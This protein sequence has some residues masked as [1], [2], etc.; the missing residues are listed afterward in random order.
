MAT[1]PIR[2]LSLFS[3]VNGLGL[4]VKLALPDSEHVCY[5]EREIEACEVLAARMADGSIS[6]APIFTDITAFNGK[7]WRGAVDLIEGGFPCTDLSVAGRQAGIHGEKSGLWFEYLRII[8]EVQPR[9]VFI[10]NVPAVIAFPAG[11]IVLSG[12]AEAG[13][14]AEW[15][16]LQA[17]EVG[18]SHKR[19]RVFILAYRTSRRFGELRESSG[20]EGLANRGNEELEHSVNGGLQDRRTSGTGALRDCGD[21]DHGSAAAEPDR[22]LEYADSK[23]GDLQQ[24]IN[25]SQPDRA[26]LPLAHTP[27]DNGGRRERGTEAGAGPQGIGGGGPASGDGALAHTDGQ[28]LQIGDRERGRAEGECD[29]ESQCSLQ[30]LVDATGQGREEPRE[31]DG[32]T[33]GKEGQSGLFDGSE[34]SGS[35]LGNPDQPGLEGWS[36]SRQARG[37]RG[38]RASESAGTELADTGCER[39]Q[40]EREQGEL[41]GTGETTGTQGQW[42]RD[43][44]GHSST[45]IPLFAPG[46]S[47]SRWPDILRE[48]PWLAPAISED[49]TIA[50]FRGE[51]DGR[52]DEFDIKDRTDRLRA[53]GNMVCP[54]QAC[55]G[56]V[57]LANRFNYQWREKD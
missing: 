17:S 49:E 4:G 36:E 53:I 5:V 6:S 18:A 7:P 27:H 51:F 22:E 13:F 1:H 55:L 46:P 39:V 21:E 56:F 35:A 42:C 24:R 28:G 9:W 25:G 43:A 16:T 10:E 40:R 44:A 12:L 38:Q 29:A 8:R 11:G 37:P 30:S 47:D 20:G 19:S 57:I 54:M 33:G 52:S 2:V 45:A 14:D 23:S 26:G 41:G 34:R 3:G 50:I 48:Y 15:I 31:Y 32:G